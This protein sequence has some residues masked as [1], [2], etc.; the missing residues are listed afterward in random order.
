MFKSIKTI[1]VRLS[2]LDKNKKLVNMWEN[3]DR[4]LYY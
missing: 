1:I 4:I 3:I 2:N